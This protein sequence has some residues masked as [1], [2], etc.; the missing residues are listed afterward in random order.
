M[1]SPVR[2][3]SRTKRR[4]VT[5]QDKDDDLDSFIVS[6]EEEEQLV[7]SSR[8]L[9]SNEE[10]FEP[11]RVAGKRRQSRGRQLGP[12]IRRD[13]R[14]QGLSNIHQDVIEDFLYNAKKIRQEVSL[15]TST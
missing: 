13:D 7:A 5:E 1:S 12:P 8:D 4:R 3:G 9:D 2:A 6:D 15:R 10:A 11:I 14:L